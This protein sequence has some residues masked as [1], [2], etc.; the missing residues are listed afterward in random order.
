[1]PQEILHLHEESAPFKVKRVKRDRDKRPDVPHHSLLHR[2]R[3]AGWHPAKENRKPD[4]HQEQREPDIGIHCTLQL[5]DLKLL[6]PIGIDQTHDRPVICIQGLQL[7]QD[8]P[9]AQHHTQYRT[10]R[11]KRLREVEAPRRRLRCPHRQNIRVS[12][13][14]QNRASSCQHIERNQEKHESHEIRCIAKKQAGRVKHQT[15]QR[16]HAQAEKHTHLVAESL[17]DQCRRDR[18][19]KIRPVKR[20]LNPGCLEIAHAHQPLEKGQ[21]RIGHVICQT[22]PC[23]AGRQQNEREKNIPRYQGNLRLG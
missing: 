7:A 8:K 2:R 11:V 13:R 17:H 19:A 14:L 4:H 1:M 6:Q 12:G 15:A 9:P 16:E 21:Q 3:A 20:Q 22:P 10:N 5:P 23:K 18:Q